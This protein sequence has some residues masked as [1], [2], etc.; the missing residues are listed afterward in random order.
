MSKSA[1]R[2]DNPAGFFGPWPPGSRVDLA[3]VNLRV[4]DE[5]FAALVEQNDRIEAQRAQ[6]RDFHTGAVVGARS[7]RAE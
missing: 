4:T 7:V 2:K 1:T 3:A 5:D 6:L